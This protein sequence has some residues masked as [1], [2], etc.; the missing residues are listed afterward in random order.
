YKEYATPVDR[1][2]AR[3]QLTAKAAEAPPA[4]APGGRPAR[5]APAPPTV[6]DEIGKALASPTGKTITRELVRGLFGVL[7]V[8]AAGTSRRRSSW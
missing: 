1:E 6:A 8:R 7:G 2:S 3:E 5:P 4:A